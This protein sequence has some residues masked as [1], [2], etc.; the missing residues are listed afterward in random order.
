MGVTVTIVVARLPAGTELGVAVVGV[1]DS[2]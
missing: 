2:E 1:T